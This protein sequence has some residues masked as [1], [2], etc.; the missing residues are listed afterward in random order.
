M[1]NHRI[2][3]QGT[4][5]QTSAAITAAGDIRNLLCDDSGNLIT[6]PAAGVIF[7][8]IQQAR[9]QFMPTSGTCTASTNTAFLSPF[10]SNACSVTIVNEHTNPIRIN[11]NAAATASHGVYIDSGMSYTIEVASIASVQVWAPSGGG[12]APVSLMWGAY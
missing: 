11:I 4:Y 7:T 12:N 5:I 9:T 2:L 10:T 1:A 6:T 3:Q 8:A